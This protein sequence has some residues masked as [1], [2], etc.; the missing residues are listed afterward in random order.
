[1]I[2]RISKIKASDGKLFDS[3]DELAAR[4]YDNE[5]VTLAELKEL[6][7]TSVA[8]GRVESVL[9]HIVLE[10]QAIRAILLKNHQRQPKPQ[11]AKAA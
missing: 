11:L 10:Q 9:K 8:T 6:L 1:M 7:R 5:I 2:Q 4:Q 3:D